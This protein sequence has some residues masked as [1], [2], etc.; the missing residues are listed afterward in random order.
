MSASRNLKP[1]RSQAHDL[2]DTNLPCSIPTAIL[3][4]CG[5]RSSGR[6]SA[7]AFP[8]LVG[9]G[10]GGGPFKN[11]SQHSVTPATYGQLLRRMPA[12]YARLGG[13]SP[14]LGSVPALTF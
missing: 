5:N 3:E 12:A 11:T 6:G 13:C 14:A 10:R 7:P 4:S 1:S 2:T 9:E 8:P